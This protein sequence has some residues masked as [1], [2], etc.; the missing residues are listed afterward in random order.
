MSAVPF[1]ALTPGVE[2]FWKSGADGR[3]RFQHCRAC[4]KLIH[5]P[6]PRCRFCLGDDIDIVAVSGRASVATYTVNWQQW[7]PAFPP[8][9]VIAI[10]E[11]EE[12]PS[13]RLTTRLVDCT[14]E[15]IGFGTPVEVRFE[16]AGPA[17]LPLFAPR[18]ST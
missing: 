2:F 13:V 6:S 5:P 17:W 11:I 7:H 12:D 16:Q 1:P 18:R 14:P 4:D 10:V 9:Y 3:L 15:E 8:P